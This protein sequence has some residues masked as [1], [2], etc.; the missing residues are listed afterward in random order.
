MVVSSCAMMNEAYII[1]IHA[2]IE[3]IKHVTHETDVR[4]ATLQEAILWSVRHGNR[5]SQEPRP[6]MLDSKS[7]SFDTDDC[8]VS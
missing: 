3:D 1:P 5:L 4:L 6:G 8:L 7:Q 2:I